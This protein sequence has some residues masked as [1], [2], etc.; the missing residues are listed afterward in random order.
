MLYR[1]MEINIHRIPDSMNKSGLSS[2]LRI[3]TTI[4]IDPTSNPIDDNIL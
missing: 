2:V 3:Q 4:Q 1:E